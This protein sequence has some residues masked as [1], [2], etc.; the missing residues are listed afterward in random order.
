MQKQKIKSSMQV[1]GAA[2]KV[3]QA[4]FEIKKLNSQWE[5]QHKHLQDQQ[6]RSGHQ[7]EGGIGVSTA[8]GTTGASS[9]S[10]QQHGME[11]DLVGSAHA[12]ADTAGASLGTRKAKLEAM[13]LPLMLEAM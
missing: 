12:G 7:E 11:E 10:S 2:M 6:E 5:D 3:M 9:S 4:H 1:A 8:Q 13:A